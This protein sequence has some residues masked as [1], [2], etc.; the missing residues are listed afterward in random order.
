MF[1]HTVN[2][3]VIGKLKDEFIKI[4]INKFIRLKS[5]M[6]CIVSDDDTEI[7]TTKGVFQLS[8]TNTKMFCL[9]KK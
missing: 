2:E 9:M 8:V 6:S 3:G 7:N 5:K 1:F 4:L